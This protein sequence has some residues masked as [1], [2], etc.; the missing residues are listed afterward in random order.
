[1]LTF[2][3]IVKQAYV[4][5]YYERLKG[6]ASP[7]TNQCLLVFGALSCIFGPMFG[8]WDTHDYHKMHMRSLSLFVL[9]EI[10]YILTIITLIDNKKH[11]LP[12]STH[13]TINKLVFCKWTIIMIVAA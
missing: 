8:F 11:L 2:Y 4:R 5:A 13:G 6:I 1:M 10:L 9:G 12:K 7:L 3:A